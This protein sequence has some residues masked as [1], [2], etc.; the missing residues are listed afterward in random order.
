M[1]PDKYDFSGY[2]TKYGIE[3]SDGRTIKHGAFAANDGDTVSLV[4]QH[5][6]NEPSNVLGKGV[7]EHRDDGMYVYGIFNE[8]DQASTAKELVQHGDVVA[9]S[10]FANRLDQRGGTVVHGQLVEVSLV[11]KGANPGATIDNVVLQHSDGSYEEDVTEAVIYTEEEVLVHTDEVLEHADDEDDELTVAEVIA[12]MNDEQRAVLYH[13]V[14]AA[15]QAS[16]ENTEGVEHSDSG[17]DNTMANVF[18]GKA[19]ETKELA[20]SELT[21]AFERAKDSKADSLR[22]VLSHADNYGIKEIGILFPDAQNIRQQPDFIKRETEWVGGFLGAIHKSPFSRIKCVHADITE[23][24]ARARGYITGKQKKDEVF[25]LLKRT[26]SPQ[27]VYKKQ[28]FDRDDLLDIT[29]D[30]IPWVKAEMEL[31]IREE[32]ARA[33]LIGDGR[34]ILSDDKIKEENIKPVWTD[35]A[36][37]SIKVN[38]AGEA[39]DISLIE[40]IIRALGNYKGSGSPTLYTTRT[41]LTDLLLLKDKMDRYLFE[42]K[43]SL[44]NRL[45]VSDV[46]TVDVMEGA[47]REVSGQN[48]NLVGILVNPRDYTLGADKGGQLSMFDDFDI[49][50]NQYKYLMETRVSGMLTIPKSAVVLE[51]NA[52]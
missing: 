19:D 3:C 40:T 24:E 4:W 47:K 49:D 14:G 13:M 23:D 39:N 20:H 35:D 29:W 34:D 36:L 26:V 11:L 32:L 9:L 17:T 44:V 5:G 28:K 12:S 43:A 10:I 18:E 37:Y 50:F 6:H 21:A 8:T 42:T 33:V 51:R 2:A 16:A 1:A 46:V 41:V 45:G 15:V 52:N 25:K 48:K 27:T 7:L 30:I 38:V 22:E 31:M